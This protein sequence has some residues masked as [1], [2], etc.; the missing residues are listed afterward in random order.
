[1]R[2]ICYLRQLQVCSQE[3]LQLSSG[4]FFVSTF[5]GDGQL[6]ALLGSQLHHCHHPLCGFTGG[7]PDLFGVFSGAEAGFGYLGE[8]ISL[9]REIGV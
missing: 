1:M 2:D 8:K 3:S 4:S 5:N 7:S 9:Y 6:H